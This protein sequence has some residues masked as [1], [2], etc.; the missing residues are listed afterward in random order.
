MRRRLLTEAKK[1]LKQYKE[2]FRSP[3]TQTW[4]VPDG[5]TSLDIFLVGGGGG[6]GSWRTWGYTGGVPGTG[7]N[8]TTK[9]GIAVSP[10]NVL[11][12]TI[13]AGGK[14]ATNYGNE[15]K[16][17]TDGGTT[18]VSINGST[19][20]AAGGVGGRNGSSTNDN[21]YLFRNY[22]VE[23]YSGGYYNGNLYFDTN[24]GTHD[25][26]YPD[27]TYYG[28]FSNNELRVGIPEFFES[29]NPI[30]AA[31]GIMSNNEYKFT[32]DFPI[33]NS[34]TNST[35]GFT[36]YSGGGRGGGGFGGCYRDSPVDRG[37]D[38]GDGVVVIRYK[39]Y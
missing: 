35:D 25:I 27:G 18:T 14:H 24:S 34:A 9:K 38:G 26:L 20:Q 13:G 19:Y 37:G 23:Q 17:A 2:Y 4:T 6:G 15:A 31:P 21:A 11:Q 5:C 7:G 3:M 32:T 33:E 22:G 29:G 16:S 39:A 1:P 36:C 10:G 30:H 8:A 12:I 28:S